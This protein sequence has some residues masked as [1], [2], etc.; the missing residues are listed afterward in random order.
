MI[1]IVPGIR[2]LAEQTARN[3][4]TFIDFKKPKN[5]STLKKLGWTSFNNSG[6]GVVLEIMLMTGITLGASVGMWGIYIS[7]KYEVVQLA[8]NKK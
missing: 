6:T 3:E 7:Q 2:K 8:Y 1:D 4:S 5:M